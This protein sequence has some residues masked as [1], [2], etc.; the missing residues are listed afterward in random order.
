MAE[1]I[2]FVEAP[3]DPNKSFYFGRPESL[4]KD[5]AEFTVTGYKIG[6]YVID[7]KDSQN[8]TVAQA[9]LLTTDLGEDL[10]LNRVL[11]GR[12]VVFDDQGK[13]SVIARSTFQAELRAHMLKLGRREDN[14][15]LLQGTA[16]DAAKHAK[17]F[18]DSKKVFCVG[19]TFFAKD[20][21]GRLV[22]GS[23]TVQ[24]SLR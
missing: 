12:K 14:P 2:T 11:K 1:F 20:E 7:G 8:A 13:A 24:F 5:G 18:F 6:N 22:P 3:V 10:P 23:V 15:E 9:I 4:F 19:Q 17:A 16:E 21:K